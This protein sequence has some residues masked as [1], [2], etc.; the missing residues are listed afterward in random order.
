MPKTE[1]FDRKEVL[2]Q[3]KEAFWKKG[4]GSTSM[5]DLVEAT[6]LNRSSIYN[7]FGD[8]FNLFLECLKLYQ[9]SE[10]SKAMQLVLKGF[11]T[12]TIIRAILQPYCRRNDFYN[13]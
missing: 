9:K 1:S 8:K 7:S 2:E 12:L 10:R 11:I 4:Y 3:A 5:Q 6:K 13:G